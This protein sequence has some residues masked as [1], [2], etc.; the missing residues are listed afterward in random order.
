M[1]V[2]LIWSSSPVLDF[3]RAENLELDVSTDF[4]L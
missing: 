2:E 4:R 3:V 1:D